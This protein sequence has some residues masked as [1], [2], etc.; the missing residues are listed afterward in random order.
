MPAPR[1]RVRPPHNHTAMFI[2]S[3]IAG[4][5]CGVL[6]WV[7]KI[8][9]IG[10]GVRLPVWLEIVLTITGPLLVTIYWG[11]SCQHKLPTFFGCFI[12]VFTMMCTVIAILHLLKRQTTP[13]SHI[14]VM[15]TS[16]LVLPT[17]CGLF[18]LL[19]RAVWM[20]L[21]SELV[22]QHAYACLGCGYDL[23]GQTQPRCPECGKEFDENLLSKKYY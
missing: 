7:V 3:G 19:M 21:I 23:R 6:F 22:P 11:R 8:Y 15:I 20:H 1:V 4:I 13:W 18:G 2:I 10:P 17:L 9:V 5:L 16:T 14:L 12:F